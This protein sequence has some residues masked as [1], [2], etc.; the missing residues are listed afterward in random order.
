[1]QEKLP[2]IPGL[3]AFTLLGY[4]AD[5]NNNNFNDWEYNSSSWWGGCSQNL[6]GGGTPNPDG[7][8]ALVEGDPMLY[9]TEWPSDSVVGIYEHWKNN[10][11]LNMDQFQ[12]WSMDNEMEIWGWTHDDMIKPFDADKAMNTYFEVAKAAR[13]MNPD[14][15]LCGPVAASEWTWFNTTN[16][17]KT[18]NGKK[19]CW[20]E[21]FI[22]R[23]SEEQK[24]TPSLASLSP[25]G[26]CKAVLAHLI[27]IVSVI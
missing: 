6:A 8:K 7:D 10:L 12:Y 11:N 4:V 1:M 22:M 23:C 26:G 17:I 14:I 13:A 20:L 18:Y 15:K 25:Q 21:Y 2:N 19:Y 16:G 9:L 24:K 27:I 3:Y 5:N